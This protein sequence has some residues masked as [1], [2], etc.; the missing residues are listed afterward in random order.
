MQRLETDEIR[1][2]AAITYPVV[3]CAAVL[4]QRSN[5]DTIESVADSIV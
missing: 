5:R 2:S 3:D 1:T 4:R